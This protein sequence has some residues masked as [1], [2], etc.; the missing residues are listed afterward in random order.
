MEKLSDRDYKLERLATIQLQLKNNKMLANAKNKTPAIKNLTPK[1][2]QTNFLSANDK[3]YQ[4][5]HKQ[6]LQS[7]IHMSNKRDTA[8]AEIDQGIVPQLEDIRTQAERQS[9]KLLQ[10]QIAQ[11]N[12]RLLMSD[13]VEARVLFNMLIQ[14]PHLLGYFNDHFPEIKNKYAVQKNIKAVFVETAVQKMYEIE[15][16]TGGVNNP[17]QV[18]G[19]VPSREGLT[20]LL[21]ALNGKAPPAPVPEN[22]LMD[23]N[24][25]PTSIVRPAPNIIPLTPMATDVAQK[26]EALISFFPS[27]NVLEAYPILQFQELE[28]LNFPS[29]DAIFLFLSN[30]NHTDQELEQLFAPVDEHSI[31]L[32]FGICEEVPFIDDS[33]EN[34][35]LLIN[36]ETDHRDDPEPND[37]L[38]GIKFPTDIKELQK[39]A[40]KLNG[41]YEL[42]RKDFPNGNNSEMQKIKLELDRVDELI[43]GHYHHYPTV[44]TVDMMTS[45]LDDV[46]DSIEFTE[47]DEPAPIRTKLGDCI[48]KVDAIKACVLGHELPQEFINEVFERFHFNEMLEISSNREMTPSQQ[49]ESYIQI[50]GPISEQDIQNLYDEVTAFMEDRAMIPDEESIQEVPVVEDEDEYM[51][52]NPLSYLIT[53]NDDSV[54]TPIGY[55]KVKNKVLFKYDNNPSDYNWEKID[56]DKYKGLFSVDGYNADH[57]DQPLSEEE[58]EWVKSLPVKLGDFKKFILDQVRIHNEYN[59]S[60]KSPNEISKKKGNKKAK[61]YDKEIRKLNDLADTINSRTP[62]QNEKAPRTPNSKVKSKKS[63]TTDPDDN[64]TAKEV[65]ERSMKGA[66]NHSKEIITRGAKKMLTT[67]VS[68]NGL[69]KNKSDVINNILNQLKKK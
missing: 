24:A 54:E 44:P 67:E 48:L 50:M 22:D 5:K 60:K 8:M 56:V 10:Q 57:P 64:M 63:P 52:T 26:I 32:A 28:S 19:L 59:E 55:F 14:K 4:T 1:L 66:E 65:Y 58:A 46:F 35:D 68:G 15:I 43:A 7:E 18:G 37:Y 61:S 25:Y 47:Q 41:E 45:I 12:V 53:V 30:P 33:I 2:V 17:A 36:A 21:D 23:M 6:T 27:S 20:A 62:V 34:F 49:S 11:Q 38:N 9:D 69:K 16:S 29:N 40:T 42:Y 3:K 13:P 31:Q 39:L 51:I